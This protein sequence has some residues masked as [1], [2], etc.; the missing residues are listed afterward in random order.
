MV[1]FLKYI[2]N[3]PFWD[4]PASAFSVPVVVITYFVIEHYWEKRALRKARAVFA[5]GWDP[6]KGTE[7]VHRWWPKK[8]CRMCYTVNSPNDKFIPSVVIDIHRGGIVE[9]P[10]H[11]FKSRWKEV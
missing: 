5:S 3:L 2:W 10:A 8:R 6:V 7:Y 1:E 11:I 9:L 4:T